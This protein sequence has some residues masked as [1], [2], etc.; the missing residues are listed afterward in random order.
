MKRNFLSSRTNFIQLPSLRNIP[1]GGLLSQTNFHSLSTPTNLNNKKKFMDKHSKKLQ[2]VQPKSTHYFLNGEWMRRIESAFEATTP[3]IKL[4]EFTEEQIKAIRE[5]GR[6]EGYAEGKKAGLSEREAVQRSH[7]ENVS[8]KIKEHPTPKDLDPSREHENPERSGKKTHDSSGEDQSLQHSTSKNPSGD[9]D[10]RHDN[11]GRP[12][13]VSSHDSTTKSESDTIS[14]EH[15]RDN[16]SQQEKV[17]EK[18]K[19]HPTAKELEHSEHH[20]GPHR[21]TIKEE[22]NKAKDIA[23][24]SSHVHREDSEV[25]SRIDHQNLSPTNPHVA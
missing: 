23:A 8:E 4:L 2:A 1:S 7:H 12:R 13:K 17:S 19:E 10:H 18:I 11:P 20:R 16:Q 9:Y 22:L 14:H 21:G 24:E 5:E 6:A 15:N 3:Q 25:K